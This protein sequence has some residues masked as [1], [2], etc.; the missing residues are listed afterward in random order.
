LFEFDASLKTKL[1]IT[2]GLIIGIV[3]VSG[4]LRATV[5]RLLRRAGADRARFWSVQALRV[6]AA[7]AIAFVVVAI[8]LRSGPQLT[9]VVGWIAAGLAIAL[10]RVI[11]AFAAYVIVLRGNIYTVGDRITIGGVRGDVVELGFMQTTVMEMGQAPGERSDDPSMWVHARQ[12][13]GRLVRITNDK[14]FDKPV[15]NYTRD[16]PYLWDEMTIP[17]P[18]GR[19]YRKVESLMLDV[20]RKHAGQFVEEG[21]RQLQ[22]VQGKYFLR[23]QPS[24]EPHVYVQLTDNWIEMSLR[25]LTRDHDI[26]GIKDAM[27]REILAGLDAAKIEVASTTAA[28]VAFPPVNVRLE[29][30]P[31]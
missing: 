15:Y 3:V 21:A 8:W 18:Y 6:L 26:R 31:S 17:I 19:D 25:F 14:I 9:A 12:Y 23:E 30:P 29:N 2:V 16:F 28:I 13:S 22:H 27:S 7:A 4:F 20:A 10:Q 1:L 24:T 5:G 11:T